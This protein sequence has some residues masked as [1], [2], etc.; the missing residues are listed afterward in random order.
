MLNLHEFDT[1][2]EKRA[3]KR[4]VVINIIIVRMENDFL[5]KPSLGILPSVL[6]RSDSASS[7][8]YLGVPFEIPFRGAL[9]VLQ[10]LNMI[11]YDMNSEAKSRLRKEKKKCN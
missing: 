8:A 2:A 5:P 3:T 7:S 9:S 4:C 1:Q 10:D 11:G 6:E